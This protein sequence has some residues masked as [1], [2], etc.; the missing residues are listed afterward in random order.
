MAGKFAN[1]YNFNQAGQGT[2]IPNPPIDPSTG[3]PWTG[4]PTNYGWK[5]GYNPPAPAS[6]TIQ[7]LLQV[8]EILI[9]PLLCRLVR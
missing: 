5:V 2:I 4:K 3:V 7:K 9:H 6:M 1:E 8:G